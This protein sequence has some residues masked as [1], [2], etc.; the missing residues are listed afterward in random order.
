MFL[1]FLKKWSLNLCLKLL[2]EFANFMSLGK[3][4]Q[5]IGIRQDKF[6][7]PEHVFLKGCFSFKTEDLVF[8]WF[9]PDYLY[10]S[11]NYRGEIFLKNLKALEQRYWLNLS[12][13]R[14]QLIFSQSFI[15]L[16]LL[17]FSW[18]Q[19]LIRFVLDSLQFAFEFLIQIWIPSWAG[20][21]KMWLN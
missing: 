17:L 11:W 8:A 15:P 2:S 21:I 10:I 3:L 19:Y 16:W 9:W 1:S 14:S 18:R 12:E 7:W 13:T 6:F 20:I 5:T 4:F